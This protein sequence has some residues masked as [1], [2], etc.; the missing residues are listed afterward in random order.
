VGVIFDKQAVLQ[1]FI[2]TDNHYYHSV[3]NCSIV[4]KIKVFLYPAN[5][6][7]LLVQSF[8][9]L[10]QSRYTECGVSECDR[11][12][13]IMGPWQ[14]MGCWATNVSSSSNSN[15]DWY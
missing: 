3:I 11:E 15:S 1:S 12:T 7:E 2:N 5:I 8:V 13:A 14:T 10:N 6:H 4:Y 9:Y